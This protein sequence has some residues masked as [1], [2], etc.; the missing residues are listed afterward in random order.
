MKIFLFIIFTI[1]FLTSCANPILV[2]D[3]GYKTH[4]IGDSDRDMVLL[5]N[6]ALK[7][8]EELKND[9]FYEKEVVLHLIG[10]KNDLRA[11]SGVRMN[12]GYH[13]F[14]NIDV[15][16]GGGFSV[17]PDANAFSGLAKAPL[18]GTLQGEIRFKN[19]AVGIDHISSPFHDDSGLNFFKV[20][21]EW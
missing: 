3:L 18:Y 16:I 5:G 1:L 4:L 8:Q 7:E 6:L 15:I 19:F 2:T 9:L 14:K 13:L 21:L 17:I 10:S 20:S 11:G 12:V